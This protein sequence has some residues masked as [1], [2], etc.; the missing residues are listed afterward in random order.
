M[1]TELTESDLRARTVGEAARRLSEA[2]R[3]GKPCAP[4]RDLIDAT[5][6]AT[7][8]AVQRR[9]VAAR[10]EAGGRISGRKIGLT[11]PAVQEQLGVDQPDFGTLFADMDVS[12]AEPVPMSGLMQP[13]IEAEIAFVLGADLTQGPLTRERAADAV[14]Y[15]VAALEIVDSRIAD[16][17]ISIADTIADNASSGRYVLS[18]RRQRLADFEAAVAVMEMTIDGDVVSR[19]T[20]RACLGDPLFALMWLAQTA[21]D[22]GAPLREGEVILSGA[23]GPMVPVLPGIHVVATVSGL[24]SVSARFAGASETDGVRAT[25]KAAGVSAAEA[26]ASAT[27]AR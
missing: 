6:V 22:L 14:A 1:S 3:A 7:A 24:G 27:E 4:V 12:G 15:A 8:Y 5:D 23:L 21:L 17:N 18:S 16:W 25:S 2:A 11:S 10:V 20:G 9:N 19:G 26:T 13:K